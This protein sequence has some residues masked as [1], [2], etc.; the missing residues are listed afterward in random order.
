MSEIII[1]N[2]IERSET[3]IPLK[4]KVVNCEL[5]NVRK[6]PKTNAEIL[7]VINEG[8]EVDILAFTNRNSEVG[9]NKVKLEDGSIGFCMSKYIEVK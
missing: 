6:R 1:G 5:L 4:G 7:R 8:E 2:E 9:F 3:A